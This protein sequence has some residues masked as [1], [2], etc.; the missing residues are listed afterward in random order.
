MRGWGKGDMREMVDVGRFIVGVRL[1]V[2]MRN[3]TFRND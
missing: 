3:D 1:S 2:W